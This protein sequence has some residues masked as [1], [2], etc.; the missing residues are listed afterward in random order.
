[1]P[2]VNVKNYSEVGGADWVVDGA[3]TI[4]GQLIMGPASSIAQNLSNATAV[5]NAVT[6][7]A[8]GGV[9]TTA[10]LTTAAAGT[11]TITINK[12]GVV[13]TDRAMAQLAGGT[14]TR[15]VAIASVVCGANTIVVT[16][17]NDDPTNALNGT[18]KFSW[19]YAK[20][21]V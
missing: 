10:A 13:A 1:M 20:V 2:N 19:D 3:L 12:A 6:T 14:N 8:N 21:S 5:A 4:N 18:V 11:Q 9:I 17:R 16:L 7:T 15:N